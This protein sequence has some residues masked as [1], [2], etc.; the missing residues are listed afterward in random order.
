MLVSDPEQRLN[1]CSV[2]C[3]S[4][5]VAVDG[6]CEGARGGHRIESRVGDGKGRKETNFLHSS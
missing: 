5:P 1:L 2:A 3:W 4:A 6:A